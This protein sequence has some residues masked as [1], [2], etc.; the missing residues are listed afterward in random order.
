MVAAAPV[1]QAQQAR[2]DTT[3]PS[4]CWRFSFGEWSP[5]L[6]WSNAGHV[7]NADSS[8]A[9]VRRIRDSVYAKDPVATGNNA[10][11]W[12]RNANGSV[13][14]LLF[15]NWWP[16][17][18]QVDFDSTIAGRRGEMLGTAAAMV[19]NAG[20]PVSKARAR[21]LQLPC[22]RRQED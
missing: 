3:V 19:A 15:P 18:V 10:M 17:G 5:P 14:L 11:T 12:Y 13:A 6:D 22:E 1:A 4:L 2:G 16:V 20:M 21:A 8:A 9:A 7:G